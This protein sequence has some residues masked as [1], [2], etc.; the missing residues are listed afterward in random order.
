MRLLLHTETPIQGVDNRFLRRLE[1]RREASHALVLDGPLLS[2][3]LLGVLL[4]EAARWIR[5]PILVASAARTHRASAFELRGCV[6]LAVLAEVR[7]LVPPTSVVLAVIV[8]PEWLRLPRFGH[9]IP[10]RVR[11]ELRCPIALPP[12]R[13]VLAVVLP[14][15]V[16]RL[17]QVAEGVLIA[18]VVVVEADAVVRIA[19]ERVVIARCRALHHRESDEGL[20]RKLALARGLQSKPRRAAR[21]VLRLVLRPDLLSLAM[22]HADRVLLHRD[23]RGDG[24]VL[25]GQLPVLLVHGHQD[26]LLPIPTRGQRQ[27]RPEEAHGG[28]GF[29]F[30]NS[31]GHRLLSEF[32][33]ILPCL[34]GDLA[35]LLHLLD[36]LLRVLHVLR[37]REVLP[38][39]L[40][41]RAASSLAAALSAAFA[42]C[43]TS[44]VK[45]LACW[46]MSFV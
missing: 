19:L 6:V 2:S 5:L 7:C 43:N 21:L 31:L 29:V 13:A 27:H 38:D 42:A 11:L 14:D 41:R 1:E 24:A 20:C 23:V 35:Q 10:L 34:F 3:V 40:L 36:R 46:P 30:A 39:E 37:D 28:D 16:N 22:Q 17:E 45:P 4:R 15:L 8:K 44:E 25:A 26:F 9:R 33:S 12:L 18:D 32:T